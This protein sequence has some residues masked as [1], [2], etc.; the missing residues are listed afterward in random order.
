M[1]VLTSRGQ[2]D[3]SG[4]QLHGDVG[5]FGGAAVGGVCGGQVSGHADG[6]V[7]LAGRIVTGRAL[8]SGAGHRTVHE[9]MC[10]GVRWCRRRRRREDRF[11]RRHLLL[12][13][14]RKG[15]TIIEVFLMSFLCIM[16]IKF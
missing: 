16:I 10:R 5:G 3:A 11:S 14:G 4:G 9:R 2:D 6:L 8:G 7:R 15:E 1:H 12:H 13:L